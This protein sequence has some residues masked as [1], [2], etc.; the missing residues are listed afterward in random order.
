M[1]DRLPQMYPLYLVT[2]PMLHRTEDVL[3][4]AAPFMGFASRKAMASRGVYIS[5]VIGWN[6]NYWDGNED[7]S[8]IT[9]PVYGNAQEV[10]RYRRDNPDHVFTESFDRAVELADA[11][12]RAQGVSD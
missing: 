10:T 1:A 12:Y 2:C 6:L 5:R 3:Y 4:A 8:P 11:R 7:H 9:V